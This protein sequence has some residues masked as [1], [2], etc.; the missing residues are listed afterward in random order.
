MKVV[1][2]GGGG[3]I[4]NV[5]C[6]KY[7]DRGDSVICVDNFHKGQCDSLFS[8]ITN[9]N[10]AFEYGSVTN[11]DDCCRILSKFDKMDRII[12][13]AG[14]VGFPAAK[15]N[16]ELSFA[17]NVQGAENVVLAR[18]N[19]CPSAPVFF[20]STGSV[21]GKLDEIC[22]E[23]SPTNPVSIYGQDKLEGEKRVCSHSNTLAYRFATC[24]GVS[25]SMRIN[26]LIND[27][28]FKSYYDKCITIFEGNA[29][30]TFIHIQDLTDSIIW[31][32]D[33]IQNLR[34]NLYNCGNESLNCTKIEIANKIK[35]FTNCYIHCADIGV[36]E[37]M[38]DYEVSYKRLSD[39]GFRPL[40]DLDTGIKEI[41]KVV[42]LLKLANQYS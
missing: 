36:D 32:L 35:D 25:P 37:D 13:L 38:R 27:F 9:P 16:P 21:Y 5:L 20:A 19:V 2:F 8:I 11:I 23:L 40:V 17:V 14:I 34:Y 30:R 41:L 6:R 24:F 31:G 39:E 4:G 18:N 15:K 10:F 7:L 1:I 29:H 28:C 3:Y 33:N 22:T 12:N 26:L 42:P